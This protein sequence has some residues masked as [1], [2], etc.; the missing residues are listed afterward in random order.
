VSV[1]NKLSNGDLYDLAWSLRSLRADDVRFM[2]APFGGFDTIGGQAVVLMDKSAATPLWQ[3]MRN[4]R[5][6]QYFAEH[7]TTSDT[8][9]D[10]VR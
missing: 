3:A 7:S 6:D 5:M 9:G 10:S 8:L 1:D 4:D 2:N